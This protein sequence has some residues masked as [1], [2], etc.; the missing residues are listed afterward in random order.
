VG[1]QAPTSPNKKVSMT[2]NNPFDDPKIL[3]SD[4]I[5]KL[6]DEQVATILEMFNKAGY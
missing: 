3:N 2:M 6:T 4:V 1:A 5:D